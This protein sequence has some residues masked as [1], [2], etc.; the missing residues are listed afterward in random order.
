MCFAD[1]CAF[2][3]L[4]LLK[5]RYDVGAPAYSFIYMLCTGGGRVLTTAVLSLVGRWVKDDHTWCLLFMRKKC[6]SMRFDAFAVAVQASSF[7][8]IRCTT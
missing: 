8:L 1:D 4:L 6:C 3:V 5:R 2:L 7:I